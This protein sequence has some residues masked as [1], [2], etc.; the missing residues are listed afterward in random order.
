MLYCDYVDF[1]FRSIVVAYYTFSLYVYCCSPN[2][3]SPH[4]QAETFYFKCR[5]HFF[6]LLLWA[7][8]FTIVVSE[9]VKPQI[10]PWRV[11]KVTYG[12]AWSTVNPDFLPGFHLQCI[13][14]RVLR[15]FICTYT[16]FIFH[17]WGYEEYEWNRLKQNRNA[18]CARTTFAYANERT[19]ERRISLLYSYCSWLLGAALIEKYRHVRASYGAL[20]NDRWRN[21][22]TREIELTGNAS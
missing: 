22:R 5:I 10:K 16:Y 21:V 17:F 11:I 1:R 19:R 8:T 6:L 13:F 18:I 4:N 7:S 3:V 9:C 20:Q 2:I 12:S 14:S 15:I